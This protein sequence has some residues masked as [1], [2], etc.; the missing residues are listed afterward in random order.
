MPNKRTLAI[1]LAACTA[2]CAGWTRLE[3][4][5][6]TSLPP[7]QQVQ[8]WRGGKKDVLHAV[9]ITADS[10]RGVPF[11]K[12]LPCADC[13]LVFVRSTVDSLRLGDQNHIIVP[14]IGIGVSTIAVALILLSALREGLY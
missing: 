12:P 14:M 10:V 11:H 4:P 9:V 3:E 6:P 5:W 2:A 7:R 1:V 13:E 8:V